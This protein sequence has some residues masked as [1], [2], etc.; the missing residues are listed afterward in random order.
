MPVAT[1]AGFYVGAWVEVVFGTAADQK[2]YRKVTA[3][4]RAPRSIARRREHRRR[5]WDPVAPLTETRISTC[6]FD[7]AL[8]YDRP[9][10]ARRPSPSGSPGLTLA[11]VPGPLLRDRLA[12][13]DA[14]RR[15]TPRSR[16]P[17]RRT[18]SSSRPPPTGSPTRW[19]G[20][21][22]GAAA[23]TAPEFVGTDLGPNRETGLLALEEVDEVALLAAPGVT[24][25]GRAARPD[26][27][28]RAADGPLRR[29]RPA[30]RHRRARRRRST[31]SRTTRATS[32]PS[33][34]PSTTRGSSS[35]TRSP[36]PPTG[37]R[38]ERAHLRRS[39]RASTTPAACTRRRPT[40]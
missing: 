6:E 8:S 7:L 24:D 12:A 15:S 9:R 19:H 3:G 21:S 25:V 23:P 28:V 5:R 14:R 4:R 13:L 34:P 37:G 10:R 18:R 31:R 29:A 22:D 1:T 20:G 17:A 33:T 11:N 39:T 40:R 27:A 32:T 36:A 26:R 38:A 35:P 16:P 2:V 30:G